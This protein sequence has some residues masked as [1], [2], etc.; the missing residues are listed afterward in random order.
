MVSDHR[1]GTSGQ[2]LRGHELDSNESKYEK[3]AVSTSWVQ[4][5]FF[6]DYT[7]CLNDHKCGTL[8]H[9]FWKHVI[10]MRKNV[11]KMVTIM[12]LAVRDMIRVITHKVQSIT[13]MMM[14]MESVVKCTI[15]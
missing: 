5:I 12:V 4:E 11:L 2:W 9:L 1:D 8:D 6:I 15:L 3:M 10:E 13:N 7:D 14:L